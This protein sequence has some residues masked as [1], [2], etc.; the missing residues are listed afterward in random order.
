ML[1]NAIKEKIGRLSVLLPVTVAIFMLWKYSNTP[2]ASMD[3]VTYLQIA[4]NILSGNGLGWQAL[5]VTPLHSILIAGVAYFFGIGDLLV[6][7]GI[8]AV[9]A[10]LLLVLA[11]YCLAQE[12][13]DRRTAVIAALFTA[14]FPHLLFI[15]SSAEG[16]ISYTFFL[17]L[18]LTL[19]IVTVKKSSYI[20]AVL[21]GLSFALAYLSRSEGFLIMGLVFVAVTVVQGRRFY[22]SSVFRMCVVATITFFVVASPYLLFL[23]KNY[24][25]W[26][27]SPKASYVMIWMKSRIYQDNDKGEIGNDEL[28]GLTDDGKKLRWQE[29]K[30]VG[31][32]L[33]YLMSHPEKSLSV[34]LHNLSLEIPGR[35]PNNSG[36]ERYPQVYPVYFALAALL[37]VFISW[38]SLKREKMAVLLAPLGILLVLPVF[39]DGWWKYLVPYLPIIIVLAARG[40]AGVADRAAEKLIPGKEARTGTVILLIIVIAISARLLLAMHAKTAPAPPSAEISVRRNLAEEAR[41]AGEWGARRF[42]PGKNYMVPWSRIVYYLNGLWTPYPVADFSDVLVFARNN[43][44]DY[45]VVEMVG[46][47]APLEVLVRTPGGIEFAELYRSSSSPYAVAFY[48]IL[49]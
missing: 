25:A 9:A 20:Y 38:G 1:S 33:G 41:K 3:G 31:D 42:G 39:T 29:P 45:I 18:S 46:D 14:I 16:E 22:R 40:I 7:A 6:A 27:I 49:Y 36:M 48:R 24:G 47:I 5:W 37:A 21:T 30:G 26:V 44:A 4:R 28:W 15:A 10:N 34:Y 8:V 23:K 13:F 2:G 11:V 19:F 43:R 17:T 12:I 32:L 35:I